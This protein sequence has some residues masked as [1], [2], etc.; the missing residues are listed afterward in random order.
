A[1]IPTILIGFPA[2]ILT[3]FCSSAEL[4]FINI[5]CTA[6][7]IWTLLLIFFGAL[8]VN[9]YSL[10]KNIVTTAFSIIGMACIAFVSILTVNLFV[11]LFG[12]VQTITNEIVY[13]I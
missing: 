5:F 4:G 3:N 13:R 6:G 9:D 1:L 8:V 2:T 10:L 12:F 11:S 7:Y